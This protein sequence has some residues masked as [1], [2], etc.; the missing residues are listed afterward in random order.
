MCV[1]TQSQFNKNNNERKR[2]IGKRMDKGI[3]EDLEKMS[4]REI[5]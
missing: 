5:L 3:R 1:Y 2:K 4:M